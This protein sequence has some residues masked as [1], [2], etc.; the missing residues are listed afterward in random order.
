MFIA[1]VQAELLVRGARSL[2]DKRSVVKG[3]IERARHRFHASVAEVGDN[4]LLQRA[5][6]GAA[7][8]SGDRTLVR[9]EADRLLEYFRGCPDAEVIDSRVEVL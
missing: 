4:D 7:F 8:V 9:A 5:R 3:L 6:I 2:K 1:I